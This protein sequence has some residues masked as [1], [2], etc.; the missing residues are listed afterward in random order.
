MQQNISNVVTL[1]LDLWARLAAC[2]SLAYNWKWELDF[3]N[4]TSADVASHGPTERVCWT[5]IMRPATMAPNSF[6]NCLNSFAYQN[7]FESVLSV[8]NFRL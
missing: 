2:P 5:H 6:T 7:A 4:A 1:Q 3:N 8:T